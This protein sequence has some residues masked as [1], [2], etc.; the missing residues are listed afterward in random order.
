M[1][2]LILKL[3]LIGGAIISAIGM[4]SCGF[5]SETTGNKNLTQTEVVL[6]KANYKVVGTVSAKSEQTYILGFGG[7]SHKSLGQS[8][9]ANLYKEAD[10]LGKPRA[11]INVSVS[12]KN[13][14]YTHWLSSAKR[15]RP[16]LLLNL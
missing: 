7:L 14:Y 11:V 8:A 9:M 5:S 15:L 1:R 13:A 6:Q 10:L 16:V 3:V 12:Y 2:K 4:T